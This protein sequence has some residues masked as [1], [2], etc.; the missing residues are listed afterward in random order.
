MK[1]ASS[2][3]LPT[4]AIEAQDIPAGEQWSTWY[5]VVANQ[6]FGLLKE[7]LSKVFAKVILIG[8]FLPLH[9]ASRTTHSLASITTILLGN[10][11]LQ[12]SVCMCINVYFW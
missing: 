8:I 4:K 11:N 9:T 12:K 2:V 6:W 5:H 10:I 1:N 3:C 7:S